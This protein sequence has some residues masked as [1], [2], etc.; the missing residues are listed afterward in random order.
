MRRLTDASA[1][2]RVPNSLV[3]GECGSSL[4]E[5]EAPPGQLR[6]VA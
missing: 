1:G 3:C 2:V 5:G 4:E 6:L